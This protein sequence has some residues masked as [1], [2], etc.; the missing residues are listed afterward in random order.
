MKM[1][2]AKLYY[3]QPTT[4]EWNTFLWRDCLKY[5]FSVRVERPALGWLSGAEASEVA[6]AR[7]TLLKIHRLI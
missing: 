4:T 1:F 3:C 7:L 6:V 5:I 2:H